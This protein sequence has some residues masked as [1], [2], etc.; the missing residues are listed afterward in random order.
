[1]HQGH[2]LEDIIFIYNKTHTDVNDSFTPQAWLNSLNDVND[3]FTPQP[4]TLHLQE[5][6]DLPVA[7]VPLGCHWAIDRW[8]LGSSLR[9]LWL[10]FCPAGSRECTICGGK[11]MWEIFKIAKRD[12]AYCWSMVW[13]KSTRA[14]GYVAKRIEVSTA[15]FGVQNRSRSSWAREAKKSNYA[16][17]YCNL[18]ESVI[19]KLLFV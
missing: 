9:H 16:V 6:W 10:H 15:R 13:S 19:I 8:P 2:L 12:C 17:F 3:Y 1:M 14:P 18:D 11:R 7:W 4:W 5:G